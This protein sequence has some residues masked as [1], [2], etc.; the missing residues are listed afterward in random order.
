MAQGRR[1][2]VGV[3]LRAVADSRVGL[4]SADKLELLGQRQSEKSCCLLEALTAGHDDTARA[5]VTAI[6]APAF[7]LSA[8]ERASFYR[9]M[10]DEAAADR[11]DAWPPAWLSALDP[12]GVKGMAG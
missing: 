12:E 11:V 4:R 8:E 7:G 10:D 6:A 9:Q 5:F 2:A 3:F 1:D